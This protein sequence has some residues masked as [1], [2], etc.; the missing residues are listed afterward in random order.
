MI[1]DGKPKRYVIGRLLA[2]CGTTS[3]IVAT[4]FDGWIDAIPVD[5]L[6]EKVWS[7]ETFLVASCRGEDQRLRVFSDGDSVTLACDSDAAPGDAIHHLPALVMTIDQQRRN[8]RPLSTPEEIT[9][10]ANVHKSRSRTWSPQ[11]EFS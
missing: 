4:D 11:N 9:P 10:P 5:C 6:I 7:G 1:R 8:F 3:C 2:C